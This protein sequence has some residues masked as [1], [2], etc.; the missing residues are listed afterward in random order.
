MIRPAVLLLRPAGPGFLEPFEREGEKIRGIVEIYSAKAS[1]RTEVSIR[2]VVRP[3]V[4]VYFIL[5]AQT[6]SV[7]RS[8]GFSVACCV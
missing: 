1:L 3:V 4:L 7:S 8:V 6:L 2:A 5:A